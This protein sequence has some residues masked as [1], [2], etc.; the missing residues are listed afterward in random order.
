M[1]QR[2]PIGIA[3]VCATLLAAGFLGAVALSGPGPDRGPWDSWETL[4]LN[5]R[6]AAFFSGRVEMKRSSDP[7]KP[8]LETRTSARF[9]GARVAQS[10]TR[11]WMDA[12]SGRTRRYESYSKKR[13]RRYYFGDSGYTVEKLKPVKDRG[14]SKRRW[15]ITSSREYDYPASEDGSLVPVFDYYGMLLRLRHEPLAAKDDETVLHVATSKGPQAYRIRVSE[16][17]QAK[18]TYTDLR[19]RKKRTVTLRMLRLRIIPADPERA[20]EGF[21]KMEGETELWVEA[22]SKTLLRL[23]GKVPKIPGRVRLSLSAAD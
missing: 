3:V 20:D 19:T 12:A 9:L 16:V 17:R 11:T 22:G 7:D 18:Q 2:R 14:G 4:R 13:G 21:L 5:A 15:E 10:R 8:T 6:S 1:N 23:S